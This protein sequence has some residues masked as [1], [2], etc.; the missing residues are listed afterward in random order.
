MLLEKR[1]W[2][3]SLALALALGSVGVA[4][5]DAEDDEVIQ[6]EGTEEE[7]LEEEEEE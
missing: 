5:D 1:R 2:M 6:E 7:P 3:A 4:C